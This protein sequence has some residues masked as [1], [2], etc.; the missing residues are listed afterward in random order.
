DL[1]GEI[2]IEDDLKE[3][4]SRVKNVKKDK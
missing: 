2:G 3:L 1:E 4:K